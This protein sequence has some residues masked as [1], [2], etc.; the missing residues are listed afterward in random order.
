MKLRHDPELFGGTTVQKRRS[1]PGISNEHECHRTTRFHPSLTG[2]PDVRFPC[3]LKGHRPSQNQLVFIRVHS[4]FPC[5]SSAEKRYRDLLRPNFPT[6]RK[7]IA[8]LSNFLI[9][10]ALWACVTMNRPLTGV[11]HSKLCLNA[12]ACR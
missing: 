1:D 10:V 8:F 2:N 4:W 11:P 3:S 5:S 6:S 9:V 7:I 12:E